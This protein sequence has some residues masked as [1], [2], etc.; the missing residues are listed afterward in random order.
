CLELPHPK[1]LAVTTMWPCPTFLAKSQW[2]LRF[3]NAYC[4]LSFMS[5]TARYRLCNTKYE[6]VLSCIINHLRSSIVTGFSRSGRT[7]LF[8][9]YGSFFDMLVAIIAG[10]GGILPGV[11]I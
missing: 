3:S 1:F 11:V 4:P 8:F 5:A 7:G 10:L 9:V 2:P 6:S